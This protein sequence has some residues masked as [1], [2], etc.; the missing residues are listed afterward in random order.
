MWTSQN[1]G[2]FTQS[3]QLSSDAWAHTVRTCRTG[4]PW[5]VAQRR[6]RNGVMFAW[7]A[8]RAAAHRRR[9]GLRYAQARAFCEIGRCVVES[10]YDSAEPHALDGGGLRDACRLQ[11]PHASYRPSMQVMHVSGRSDRTLTLTSSDGAREKGH[12]CPLSILPSA[13]SAFAVPWIRDT[14]RLCRLAT[15]LGAPSPRSQ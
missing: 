11:V 10:D 4:V 8:V 5:R 3:I 15:L 9:R 13:T 12:G 7:W 2:S 1:L 6:S 14:L